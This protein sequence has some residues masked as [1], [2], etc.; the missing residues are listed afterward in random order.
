[1][2]PELEEFNRY[3][4]DLPAE[5]GGGQLSPI[6]MTLIRTYLAWKLS[7]VPQTDTGT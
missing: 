1:M 6:E 2:A 4:R 7:N 3:M 5:A